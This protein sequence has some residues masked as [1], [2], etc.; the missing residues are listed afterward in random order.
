MKQIHLKASWIIKAPRESIY[1]IM[2]DFEHFPQHFPKVAQSVH[3]VSQDGNNYVIAA[4]T[5]SFGRTWQVT[6]NTQVRPPEGFIS[7]NVSQ[8]G[9]EHEKFLMEET[10]GGT[11]INYI[12]D[13]EI[14]SLFFRLFG[15]MLISWYAMKFWE[16]AVI[17]K[18]KEMLEQ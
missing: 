6:M 17:D 18:L 5:K 16:H 4:E 14:K 3:I 11:R 12:N 8:I 1:K 13:V 10:S 2:T 7:E 9:I 15:T